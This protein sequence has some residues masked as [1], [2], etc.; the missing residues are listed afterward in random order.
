MIAKGKLIQNRFYKVIDED[1]LT[2]NQKVDL[3]KMVNGK[4]NILVND[5]TKY[6]DE[7]LDLLFKLFKKD[8]KLIGFLFDA[9]NDYDAELKI[10]SN[11][12]TTYKFSSMS[13]E[14]KLYL[15]KSNHF[16]LNIDN[17]KD[18]K[19]SIKGDSTEF[20][21]IDDVIVSLVKDDVFDDIYI[22]F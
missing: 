1:L 20:K 2:I 13:Y 16:I 15:I 6:S 12:E 4:H 17:T 5:I 21:D 3:I 14:M 9:F 22:E 7:E 8:L 18:F 11:N 10:N 19:Y